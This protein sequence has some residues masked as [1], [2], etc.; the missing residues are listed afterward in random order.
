MPSHFEIRHVI[1]DGD[2]VAVHLGMTAN[3]TGEYQGH[4]ATGHSVDVGEM[5]FMRLEY[6]K[7]TEI[8]GI[9]DT[10]REHLQLG[11]I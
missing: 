5:L 8:W 1:D 4:S 7:I 9:F 2:H 6:G 11:F 10:Y 3:Q